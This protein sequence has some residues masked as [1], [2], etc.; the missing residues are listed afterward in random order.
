MGGG[1]Q[2]QRLDRQGTVV[3]EELAILT[4][5]DH[6]GPRATDEL[7]GDVVEVAA[8]ATNDGFAIA[9]VVRDQLEIGVR[10]VRS[11]VDGSRIGQ[12]RS[13]GATELA[14]IGIRGALA[15][16]SSAAGDIA[17]LYRGPSVRCGDSREDGVGPCYSVTP[18]ALSGASWLEEREGI[19][20]RVPEPCEAMVSGFIEVRERWYYGICA[21]SGPQRMTT[22]YGLDLD[23]EY[24]HPEEILAGCAPLG[25]A[26]HH[27][28]A[29]VVGRCGE[30]IHA[31][32]VDEA[33]R[34]VED[35]GRIQRDLQCVAGVPAI[36]IH[37]EAGEVLQ[38]TLEGRQRRI[39]SLL[40]EELAGATARAIWT[41][42]AVLVAKPGAGEV[43]IHRY[44]CEFDELVRT[45]PLR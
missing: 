16:A 40:P 14:R 22:V 29:L 37:T 18:T 8:T 41:G 33:G 24:A 34:R 42:E 39:E 6:E 19:S 7:P 13:H 21:G 12:L 32:Q 9:F 15:L 31:V 20:L 3:G 36:H 25:V 23:P 17:L 1:L 30:S 2:A 5:S 28:G 45:N 26:P 11:A 43:G 10:S 35:L 44:G 27:G 38:T 4:D